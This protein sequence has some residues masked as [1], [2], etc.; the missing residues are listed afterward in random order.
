MP[1]VLKLTFKFQILTPNNLL[2]FSS[3]GYHKCTKEEAA[4][5]AALIYRVKFSESKQ[6][7]QM[8]P[9]MLRELVPTDLI[10]QMSA[11]DWKRE[12]VRCYNQGKRED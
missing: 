1:P 11:A 12:I 3:T 5:L 9:Q 4:N 6:E 10:K 8:I 7:L 2:I